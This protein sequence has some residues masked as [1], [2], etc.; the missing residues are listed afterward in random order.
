VTALARGARTT[1]TA[2][3]QPE[4]AGSWQANR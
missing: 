3:L 2:H 1:V 4:Y